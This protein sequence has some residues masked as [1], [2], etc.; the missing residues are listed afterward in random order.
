MSFA[1][2]KKSWRHC[3]DILRDRMNRT[4]CRVMK[5]FTG[6]SH[7][8]R[9]W[10][11]RRM[12]LPETEEVTCCLSDPQLFLSLLSANSWLANLRNR[13]FGAAAHLRSDYERCTLTASDRDAVRVEWRLGGPL[14][15]SA[16]H[17]G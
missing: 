5:G 12:G 10:A 11:L 4:R 14:C 15:Q 13:G 9:S 7:R 6:S 3:G 8:V 2:E 16:A 1:D 17:Y